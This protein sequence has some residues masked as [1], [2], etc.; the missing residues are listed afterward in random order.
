M[1]VVGRYEEALVVNVVESKPLAVGAV[2]V[3]PVPEK[4]AEPSMPT[5]AVLGT[6]T[7]YVTVAA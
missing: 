2:V 1:P 5:V 7:P 4:L 3:D 6:V